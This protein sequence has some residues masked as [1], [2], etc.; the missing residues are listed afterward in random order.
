[1]DVSIDIEVIFQHVIVTDYYYE[2]ILA[3]TMAAI[4]IYFH[5]YPSIVIVIFI[6]LF[7]HV[8]VNVIALVR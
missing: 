2:F 6:Q 7:I 1:M 4:M 5:T 3:N 8:N